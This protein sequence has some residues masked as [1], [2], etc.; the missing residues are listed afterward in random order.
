[1]K[2]VV[3][4]LTFLYFSNFI[5]S[6][7]QDKCN[8]TDLN[9]KIYFCGVDGRT[10]SSC[11]IE[12]LKKDNKEVSVEHPGL[13]EVKPTEEPSPVSMPYIFPSQPAHVK[14]NS[15][16]PMSPKTHPSELKGANGPSRE[17]PP[18][19]DANETQIETPDS[20]IFNVRLLY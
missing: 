5:N 19:R 6:S 12:C 3:I 9:D 8:C 1:M 15:T 16:F 20:K 13:C 18:R 4:I 10:Y 17:R 11:Q 14:K 2:Q 7:T